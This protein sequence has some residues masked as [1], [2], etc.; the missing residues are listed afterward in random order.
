MMTAKLVIRIR[1]RR[2]VRG[3]LSRHA[4]IAEGKLKR[5]PPKD[6]RSVIYVAML[7]REYQDWTRPTGPLNAFMKTLGFSG[8]VF[9]FKP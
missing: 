3:V 7:F 9:R 5:I 1:P 4:L 6:P 8:K 2:A